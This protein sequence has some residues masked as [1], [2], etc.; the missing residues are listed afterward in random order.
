MNAPKKKPKKP[1]T[2]NKPKKSKTPKLC[3]IRAAGGM[4]GYAA[5][6]EPWGHEGDTHFN[7]GDGFYSRDNEVE[8]HRRQ[9]EVGRASV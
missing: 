5:C 4:I 2:T 7:Q 1:K 9:K 6:D 8:H 3:G